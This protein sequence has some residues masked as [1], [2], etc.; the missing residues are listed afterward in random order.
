MKT[1]YFLMLMITIS[2]GKKHATHEKQPPGRDDLMFGYLS[3]TADVPK[4]SSATLTL[5]CK[6]RAELES[7][8]KSAA[9]PLESD[10]EFTVTNLKMN[11]LH[12]PQDGVGCQVAIK[13]LTLND[14]RFVQDHN[15]DYDWSKDSIV[16]LFSQ[17]NEKHMVRVQ[18][19]QQL[20][21][22]LSTDRYAN[23][24]LFRVIK[25]QDGDSIINTT[26]GMPLASSVRGLAL[27]T[28]IAAD[29]QSL[30]TSVFTGQPRAHN[31][32][33]LLTRQMRLAF[34]CASDAGRTLII[35]DKLA[36][37]GDMYREFNFAMVRGTINPNAARA[38]DICN[39]LKMTALPLH[40]TVISLPYTSMPQHMSALATI[41]LRSKYLDK[42]SGEFMQSCHL[43]PLAPHLAPWTA[44]YRPPYTL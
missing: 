37:D 34:S 33:Y 41:V 40:N 13:A 1:L 10:K 17:L 15:T 5:R 44:G 24:F 22:T 36:C 19:E 23:R 12:L 26:E 31:N 8:K 28:W 29:T 11:E 25:L 18:I 27:T 21:E 35:E 16:D 14:K 42:K 7:G 2:C 43:Y 6:Q 20:P 38:A 3:H 39:T 9:Q 32:P 4:V 30:P